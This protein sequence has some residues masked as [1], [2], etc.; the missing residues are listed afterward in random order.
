[1]DI[2][3]DLKGTSIFLV[4]ECVSALCNDDS[5]VCVQS[6]SVYVLVV[7]FVVLKG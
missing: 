7:I 6:F 2:L 5:L 4:G 3:L 1:M